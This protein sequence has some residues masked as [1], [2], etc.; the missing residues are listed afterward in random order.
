MDTYSHELLDAHLGDKT[1]GA[2]AL[3]TELHGR[4]Q[5]LTVFDRAYFRMHSCSPGKLQDKSGIG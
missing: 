5:S 4:N 1:Q 2:L 3:A